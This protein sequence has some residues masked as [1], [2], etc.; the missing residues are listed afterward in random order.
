MA[1]RDKAAAF[2]GKLGAQV[3]PAAQTVGA[4]LARQSAGILQQGANVL[5]D[6][7]DAA[8]RRGGVTGNVQMPLSGA[9]NMLHAGS[10][11]LLGMGPG[12]QTAL[13]Y[14]GIGTAALAAGTAA[15]AAGIT[16]ARKR[17]K[18]RLAGQNLG[19]QLGVQMPIVY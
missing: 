3:T 6:A 19:A 1:I 7:G 2:L 13:G 8:F 18:E 12:G 11:N 10:Q 16:G 9:S 5:A 15:A 14:G 4:G 17:R